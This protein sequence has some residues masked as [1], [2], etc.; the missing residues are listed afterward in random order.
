MKAAEQDIV[1]GQT[2]LR[3]GVRGAWGEDLALMLRDRFG[4]ELIVLSCFF[5]EAS[6]SFAEGYNA[7]IE[8]HLDRVHGEG[9]LKAVWVEVKRRRELRYEAWHD[10]Q[11][12]KQ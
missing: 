11:N 10:Q 3:Y 6:L 8:A 7:T 4:V 12:R 2:K 5:S 1:V 9:S